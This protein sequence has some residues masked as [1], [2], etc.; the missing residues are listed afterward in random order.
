MEI[1]Q[2]LIAEAA[3]CNIKNQQF[4]IAGPCSFSS[5]EELFNIAIELKK[6][7]V[8]YLR[9]GCFKPRTSPYSFQGLLDEGIKHLIKIKEITG[10]KI[11]TELM[12]WDQVQKYKEDIDIIQIGSRNM[13]NYDLLSKL[14]TINNTI[15]LKRG[16]SAT[17]EEWLGAAEY[18]AKNGNQNIILCER[19]IRSFDMESRNV[20]DLQAIPI[21]KN[22]C[23]LPIIVDPS[24][25]SGRSDIIE[26]MCLAAMISGADGLEI[27][28]HTNP[29]ISPSDANQTID[30]FKFNN[31]LS[32]LKNYDF[33]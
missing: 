27:E 12:N 6:L 23:S 25:A 19:G 3:K 5:Y 2:Y 32:K 22:L 7:G 4:I 31:I 1:K 20:L 24:H 26:P 30:V 8:Q 18:I 10:L 29:Q 28:V 13:Y 9:A 15:L 14:G 17:I 16:L 11:V 33:I 21:V